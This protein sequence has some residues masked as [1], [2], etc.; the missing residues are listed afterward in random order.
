MASEATL[1]KLFQACKK[2]P[3]FEGK[4]DEQI[5]KTCLKY[6]NKSD[7]EIRTAIGNIRSKDWES[8]KK[9]ETQRAAMEQNK[10]KMLKLHE[11]E[12]IEHEED[13]KTAD[14]VLEEFFN[15]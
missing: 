15:S 8:R 4:T 7:S 9:S 1:Q 13:Q 12:A 5:W 10:E 6:R 11:D 3:T 14:N 2:S